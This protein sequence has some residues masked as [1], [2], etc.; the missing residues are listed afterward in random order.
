MSN[1]E[2]MNS[3][4]KRTI[5]T[6]E[7]KLENVLNSIKN[8]EWDGHHIYFYRIDQN[9]DDEVVRFAKVNSIE[10]LFS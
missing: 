3:E 9:G 5:Y 4:N 10:D 2:K 6:G 7:Q 1:E 8:G